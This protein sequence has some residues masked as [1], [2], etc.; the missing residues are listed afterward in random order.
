MVNIDKI[1]AMEFA[2]NKTVEN[3]MMFSSSR[4][5]VFH[6]RYS[7][8]FRNINGKTSVLESLF[9][10]G[11]GLACNFIKKRF[12]HSYFSVIIAQFLRT[13]FLQNTSSG[14]FWILI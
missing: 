11:A 14:C 12:Q 5:D 6:N 4:K 2:H 3:S 1:T 10:K 9:N 7:Y 13:A 8:E